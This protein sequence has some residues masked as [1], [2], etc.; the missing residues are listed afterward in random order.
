[1][2][3]SQI[4]SDPTKLICMPLLAP[5]CFLLLDYNYTGMDF[6]CLNVLFFFGKGKY[7]K[8]ATAGIQQGHISDSAR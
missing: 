2:T 5:K 8:T 4:S 7:F 1:M 3:T 6:I